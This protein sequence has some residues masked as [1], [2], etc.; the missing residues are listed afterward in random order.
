MDVYVSNPKGEDTQNVSGCFWYGCTAG[1]IQ[2]RVTPKTAPPKEKKKVIVPSPYMFL[3]IDKHVKK[4]SS[5][6][7]FFLSLFSVWFVGRSI[8]FVRYQDTAMGKEG[9]ILLTF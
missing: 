2:R 6:T 3:H 7:S 8:V 1:G 9:Y 5:D 4:V